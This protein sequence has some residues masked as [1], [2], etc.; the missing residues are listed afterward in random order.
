MKGHYNMYVEDMNDLKLSEEVKS[1]IEQVLVNFYDE[2]KMLIKEWM[3]LKK[4]AQ[5]LSVST[6]TL[7]KY[8]AMGL[9]VCV[10]EG[11]NRVSRK[12]LDRFLETH[13]N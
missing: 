2:K 7:A 6:N 9:K 13:S 8:R 1:I 5:Y 10:I 3:S 11:V 12:E 4:A